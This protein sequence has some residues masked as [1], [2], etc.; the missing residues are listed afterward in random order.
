MARFILPDIIQ[1]TWMVTH[2][3][4]YS[5]LALATK[6]HEMLCSY[7]AEHGLPQANVNINEP[8]IA[9]EQRIYDEIRAFEFEAKGR[10][11][12]LEYLSVNK[13]CDVNK[14]TALDLYENVQA[15]VVAAAVDEFLD[16]LL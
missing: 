14:M 15:D 11:N 7:A 3:T 1:A 16:T 13:D 4:H 10:Y 12:D 5:Y 2:G 6:M 9:Y 8:R